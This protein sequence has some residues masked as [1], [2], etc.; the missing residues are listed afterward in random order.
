MYDLQSIVYDTMLLNFW[1]SLLKKK[2]KQVLKWHQ[3]SIQ[4]VIVKIFV[5][6]LLDANFDAVN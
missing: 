4:Y 6:F 2:K 5:V 1:N 3:N